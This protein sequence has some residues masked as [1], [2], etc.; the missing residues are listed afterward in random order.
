MLEE[1]E[2]LIQMLIQLARDKEQL[3]L[4]LLASA[5][6]QPATLPMGRPET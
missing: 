3:R 6:R 2:A 1:R 4:E 5:D